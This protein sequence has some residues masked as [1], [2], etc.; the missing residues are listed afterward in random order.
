LLPFRKLARRP[1]AEECVGE[2]DA[3]C[4][5]RDVVDFVPFADAF[6]VDAFELVFGFEL[7]PPDLLALD[8]GAELDAVEAAELCA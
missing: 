3:P 4:A 1:L 2:F 7:F 6:E 5:V 8:E